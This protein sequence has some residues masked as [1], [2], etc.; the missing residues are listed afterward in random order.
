MDR[1]EEAEDTEDTEG[2]RKEREEGAFS[3]LSLLALLDL[4]VDLPELVVAFGEGLRGSVS[5]VRQCSFS[6]LFPF[7]PSLPSLPLA[8]DGR[9]AL[10]V[11]RLEKVP[12]PP[13]SSSQAEAGIGSE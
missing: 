1:K 12:P 7:P 8:V 3:V 6:L 2:E 10:S 5:W 11:R 13:P 4:V 9:M